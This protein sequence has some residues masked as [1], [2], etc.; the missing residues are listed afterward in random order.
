[1]ESSDDIDHSAAAA[2]EITNLV[3]ILTVQLH[4]Q[5]ILFKPCARFAS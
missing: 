5:F 4:G 2:R 3:L 1:M